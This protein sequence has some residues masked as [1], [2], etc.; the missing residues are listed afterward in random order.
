MLGGILAGIF[1]DRMALLVGHNT[2]YFYSPVWMAASNI[3]AFFLFIAFYRQWKRH[4]G[5]N[6]YV[7]PL[8]LNN[9]S[10]VTETVP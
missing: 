3:P 2:A 6:H 5:D 10:Q 7:A 8:P 9:M 1:L 4:G